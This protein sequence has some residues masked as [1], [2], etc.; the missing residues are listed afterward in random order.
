MIFGSR[1]L[2]GILQFMEPYSYCEKILTC[3]TYIFLLALL[4]SGHCP[5]KCPNVPQAQ[6]DPGSL[7]HLWH[8]LAK[9]P[10]ELQLAQRKSLLVATPLVRRFETTSCVALWQTYFRESP[11]NLHRLG[12][13]LYASLVTQSC[14]W[15][16]FYNVFHELLQIAVDV[17]GQH[18]QSLECAP[19]DISTPNVMISC[20]HSRLQNTRGVCMHPAL[21]APLQFGNQKHIHA[22][23]VRTIHIA[24]V[25]KL[26]DPNTR[27]Y[28]A[29]K[30]VF[31]R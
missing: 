28:T 17:V 27:T 25:L 21:C 11:Q 24:N 12:E 8:S 26:C 16:S 30:F 20:S 5:T 13:A 19:L 2:R 1:F 6:H 23:V 4:R 22:A 3:L 31:W 9:C 29:K 18:H 10:L 7:F 15:N 14:C